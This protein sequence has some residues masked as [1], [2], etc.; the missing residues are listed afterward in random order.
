MAEAGPP[1]DAERSVAGY[2]DPKFAAVA[3]QLF[4]GQQH[5]YHDL[6]YGWL[7]GEVL[8]RASGERVSGLVARHLATPLR[9]N[10]WSGLP[11]TRWLRSNQ[12]AR[13]VLV[14]A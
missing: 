4:E 5:G 13:L 1:L 2:V 9:F 8:Q 14:P 7:L 10:L 6:S 11:I 3:D 12:S